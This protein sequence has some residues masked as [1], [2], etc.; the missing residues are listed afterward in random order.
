[1]EIEFCIHKEHV[2]IVKLQIICPVQKRK[3]G[4]DSFVKVILIFYVFIPQRNLRVSF[5]EKEIKRK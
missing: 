1:M 3:K 4:G 5:H 2:S